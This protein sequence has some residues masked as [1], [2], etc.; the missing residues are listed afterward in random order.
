[1]KKYKLTSVIFLISALFWFVSCSDNSIVNEPTVEFKTKSQKLADEVF[2]N[3]D[4][5][6]PETAPKII[7]AEEVYNSRDKNNLILDIRN[8]KDFAAGHIKGAVN[9]K[10][11]ELIDFA[12]VK[13]FPMYDKVVLVCY[14]GQSASYSNAILQM[15]G[16]SNVYVMKWGMCS[17]NK[18]FS[19]RWESNV[20]DKG[21][22][23]L[24]NKKYEKNDSLSTLPTIECKKNTGPE[25]LYL[26][27]RAILDDG[28]GK[29]SVKLNYLEAYAKDCYVVSYQPENIYKKNHLKN[30]IYY[31]SESS[32]NLSTDLLSLP[33]EKIIVVYSNDA[34][35]SA[36]MAG[37]LKVLGYDA[38]TLKYG[39]SSFMNSKMLDFGAGFDEKMTK[40][41]PFETS[42]Y[43]EVEEEVQEGGC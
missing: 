7:S 15:L 18:K 41:Y 8:A 42:V 34:H 19:D 10:L 14:T 21:L 33:N 29:A 30:A 4:F 12:Q 5:I 17:W 1:M 40:N 23:K 35:S 9:L 32:L 43:I 38:K 27:S 37:F 36:Y 13:G 2:K 39:A 22:S 20:S 6:S 31:G 16:H 24:R 28:F 3:G 25:I 11:K 26:R